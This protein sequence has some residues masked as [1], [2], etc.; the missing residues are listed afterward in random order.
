MNMR[1]CC[2]WNWLELF[3][4]W[5]TYW[6]TPNPW[7][8]QNQNSVNKLLVLKSILLILRLVIAIVCICCR[9]VD[10]PDIS[11]AI[12]KSTM[13]AE[14]MSSFGFFF[15]KRINLNID[16]LI[17]LGNCG[18]RSQQAPAQVDYCCKI[19]CILIETF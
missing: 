7:S 2:M 3:A 14:Q 17:A 19:K 5:G 16:R 10:V 18:N 9:T 12:S 4:V 15:F 8:L 6:P 13:K 11:N 1:H